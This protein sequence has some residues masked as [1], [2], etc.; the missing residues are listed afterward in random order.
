VIRQGFADDPAKRLRR[1]GLL[2]LSDGN[3]RRLLVIG[4]SPDGGN[5][6]KTTR[7]IGKLR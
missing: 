7:W 6:L 5:R 1:S 4:T 2:L 3:E